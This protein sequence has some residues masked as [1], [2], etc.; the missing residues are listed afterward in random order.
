MVK[1]ALQRTNALGL[2]GAGEL[3]SMNDISYYAGKHLDGSLGR[4][5]LDAQAINYN[6]SVIPVVLSPSLNNEVTQQNELF[7]QSGASNSVRHTNIYADAGEELVFVHTGRDTSYGGDEEGGYVSEDTGSKHYNKL[8]KNSVDINGSMAAGM[9]N[10]INIV[11]GA[12]GDIALFDEAER[13]SLTNKKALSKEDLQG[14]ITVAGSDVLDAQGKPTGAHSGLTEETA[15]TI[16]D[17]IKLGSVDYAQTLMNRYNEIMLLISEYSSDGADSASYIGY[18]AEAERL[19]SQMEK[20]G[21]VSYV[22]GKYVL[23][24]R[25]MVDYVELPELTASGGNITINTSVLKSSKATGS[26]AANG[27]PEINVTN[28][29]NLMLRLQRINVDDGGITMSS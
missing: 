15:A 14:K 23:N 4:L 3:Y 27:S 13:N 28:N 10:R 7:M 21:E 5:E 16:K 6:G 22:D 19:L 18:K 12:A 9:D 2:Y 29:T 11:V 24:A 26:L 20:M 8:D 17:S 25:K 1:N